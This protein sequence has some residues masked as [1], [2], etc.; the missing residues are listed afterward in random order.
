M[1]IVETTLF[2]NQVLRAIPDDLYAKL[3]EHLSDFPD[4]GDLLRGGSGL[5][6]LRWSTTDGGK[7]G[8]VRVIYFWRRRFDQVYLIYL[9]AKNKRANLTSSQLHRLAKAARELK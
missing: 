9:F 3:Q 7:S 2:T 1:V 6:K 8:G 5:R 4:S